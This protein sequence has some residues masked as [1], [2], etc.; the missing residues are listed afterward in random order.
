MD[1]ETTLARG[2]WNILPE[3]FESM[4]TEEIAL[5]L[6]ETNVNE[7]PRTPTSTQKKKE[8]K[9]YTKLLSAP[10]ENM[11]CTKPFQNVVRISG[12]SKTFTRTYLWA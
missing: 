11:C 2:G 6:D 7:R 4:L 9:K 1:S 8:Q 10:R 12:S 3:E 5:D